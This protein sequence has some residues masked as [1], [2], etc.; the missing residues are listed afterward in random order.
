[1]SGETIVPIVGNLTADPE[2]RFTQSGKAVANFTIA[3]TPRQFDRAKN[4]WTDSDK[5]LFL[6]C[7]LWGDY[8][9]Q[10]ADSLRKGMRV[11]ALGYLEQSSYETKEGEKRTSIDLVVQEIGPVLRDRTG[12]AGA[13]VVRLPRLGRLPPG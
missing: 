8:A 10:V 2:L 7:T 3:S 4:E 5:G 1:M 13:E 9:R 12:H 11:M 6:R